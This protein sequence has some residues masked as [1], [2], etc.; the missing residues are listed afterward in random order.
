M[1]E[2]LNKK[3]QFYLIAAVILVIIILGMAGVANYIS[4]KEEPTNFYDIGENLGL[5]GAWVIDQGIYT[6]NEELD[7]RI[8]DFTAKFA[9]YVAAT[10]EEFELTIIH[11]DSQLGTVE[12]YDKSSIGEICSVTGESEYCLQN[13]EVGEPETRTFTGGHTNFVVGDSNYEVTLS[14]NQNFLFVMTT[15]KG[16]EKYIYE[17]IE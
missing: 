13:Y 2:R 3:A 5:E 10:G 7:N 16:F 11:G 8:K 12:Q 14:E 1:K 15:S 6:R 4:V 9:D 17:N